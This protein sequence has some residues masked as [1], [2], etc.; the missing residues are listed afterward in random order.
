MTIQ[1]LKN[2]REEIIN[3]INLMEYDLK[4]AM[5]MAVNICGNCEDTDELKEELRN[6][7]RKVKSTKTE[8]ILT[9]LAQIEEEEKEGFRYANRDL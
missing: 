6:Y 7:C 1:D 2:N 8:R 3:F 9:R 5:E 4:F